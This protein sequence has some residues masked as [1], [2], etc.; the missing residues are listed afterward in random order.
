MVFSKT[1][2]VRVTCCGQFGP[3]SIP[4]ARD[5]VAIPSAQSSC[6]TWAYA[7][8]EVPRPPCPPE[9]TIDAKVG[10]LRAHRCLSESFVTLTDCVQHT[11]PVMADW[12]RGRRVPGDQSRRDRFDTWGRP[13]ACP[14]GTMQSF[15]CFRRRPSRPSDPL[16]ACFG[17][18]PCR[19]TLAQSGGAA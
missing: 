4:E 17:L 13:R 18:S 10:A 1:P 9:R 15:L 11:S 6:A 2:S 12:Q 5:V 19:G 16:R 14:R 8:H 7:S 3:C